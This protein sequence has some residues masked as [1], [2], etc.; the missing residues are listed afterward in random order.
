MTEAAGDD[1]LTDLDLDPNEA[2]GLLRVGDPA[3]LAHFGWDRGFWA[4][5]DEM[6]VAECVVLIGHRDGEPLDAGWSVERLNGAHSGDAGEA[7][8]AEAIAAFQGQVYVFGSHHGDKEG[9]LLRRVQWVARFDEASVVIDDA[10]GVPGARITVAADDFRLHRLLNDAL[11]ASGVDLLPMRQLTR[12]SFIDATMADLRG[13][14]DEG[15]VLP[16]DWVLNIEGADFT[17]AG[18]LL[19][20]LR[21]PVTADGRPLVIGL[22]GWDR[23]FAGG[24]PDVEAIWEIDAVGRN[25]TLAGVRDLC[26]AGDD[27]HVVSG[28]LDSAGKGSVIRKDYPDGAETMATHFVARLEGSRGGRVEAKAVKEFPDNPRIEG[29]AADADGRF[30]YVSDEDEYIAV[31]STPLQTGTA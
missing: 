24:M 23:L 2:S 15:N 11:R 7:K 16:D 8:D 18:T 9:P 6:D 13:T 14:P 26:T 1:V 31:R 29:I 10:A 3:L 28:D 19:L 4:V 17:S 27:L 21:F 20:G 30:F 12:T 22:V 5:L 25:G